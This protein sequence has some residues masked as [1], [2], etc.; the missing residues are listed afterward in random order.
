MPTLS[1]VA[2]LAGVGVMS[3][4]R[5][6]NGTRRVSPEV[7][8]R[9][10]QALDRIG[11]I[12]NEAARILKGNRSSVIGLIVPDLADPFFAEL[13]H[14]VQQTA[15]HA[16]YM[17]LMASSDHRADLETSETGL[18]VQRRVAG[19]LAVPVGNRNRHFADAQ[20]NGVP[21]IAIDRPIHNVPADTLTVDNFA[22]SRRSTAHLVEH[23]HRHILC[24]ADTE[25]IYTKLQRVAGYK[26]AMRDAKLT[27]R[28]CLLGPGASTIT[29]HLDRELSGRQRAT[30]IFAESNLV[31]VAVLHELRRRGLRLAKDIALVCFDDFSAASLVTPPITV[32]QQP[33]AELGR[34]AAEL[35]LMRLGETQ[36]KAFVPQHIE[37]PTRLL[38]RESCGQ[39]R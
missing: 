29:E 33:V 16:G 17:T 11:Y 4:S 12:P 8:R 20:S 30:A 39:H 34:K 23:G 36:H 18:M 3:V 19:L 28:V 15:W 26:R 25:R 27:A 37:L 10:R 32:I 24:V 2:K 7:E 35:L 38:I 22:A 21:V 5:V 6:V 9:V 14:A 13:G 31:A 1:D